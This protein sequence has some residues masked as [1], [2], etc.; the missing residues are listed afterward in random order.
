MVSLLSKACGHRGRNRQ[1]LG[2]A[3]GDKLAWYRRPLRKL[4]P[5]TEFDVRTLADLPRVDVAYSYAGADGTAVR[6]F[7]AA[8]AKGIVVAGFAPGFVTPG[9]AAALT[10]AL[11]RLEDEPARRALGAIARRR[12]MA[13]T[14]TAGAR[15]A[16]AAIREAAA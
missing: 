8:G 1:P 13:L 2:H 12:A 5:D 7:T 4:A 14:W 11:L 6:A 10:S 9:D 15:S 3:D 16:L